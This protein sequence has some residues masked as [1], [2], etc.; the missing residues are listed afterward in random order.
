MTASENPALSAALAQLWNKFLPQIEE[1]VAILE[2]AASQANNTLTGEQKSAA[3]AAAHKLAGT[4][5]TFGLHTGTLLAREA[6]QILAEDS[7][8]DTSAAARLS[9]IAT[10]LRQIIAN[11]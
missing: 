10:E 5:G 1:R 8:L 7:N 11:R 6:E 3:H 2:S 9:E 4:L